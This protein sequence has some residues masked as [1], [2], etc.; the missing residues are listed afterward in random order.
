MV[1]HVEVIGPFRLLTPDGSAVQLK[2]RKAQALLAMLASAGHSGMTRERIVDILW[3]NRGEQQARS[4]LRQALTSVRRS[5]QESDRDQLLDTTDDLIRLNPRNTFTDFEKLHALKTGEDIRSLSEAVAMLDAQ[6]LDGFVSR[7]HA[8]E[9]WLSGE[10]QSLSGL[11]VDLMRRLAQLHIAAGDRE[12]AIAVTQRQLARDEL[13]ETTHRLL[14]G[15]YAEKGD[16][17]QALQ[18]FRVCA[19]ILKQQLGI[20]PDAATL[21]LVDEIKS[22]SSAPQSEP[23]IAN[24]ATTLSLAVL[25]L[26]AITGSQQEKRFADAI[27]RDLMTEL[28]RF[29]ALEVAGAIASLT[30]KGRDVSPSELKTELGVRFAVE[31][32]VEMEGS[33]TRITVQ[34][35]DLETL[36]QIWARRYTVE[37]TSGLQSRD[38]LVATIAG[39]LYPPL[40]AHLRRETLYHPPSDANSTELYAQLF[41]LSNFP[42]QAT[43][44]TAREQCF[45]LIAADP[46]HVQVYESLAWTY[47]HDAINAW[48]SN[49]AERLRRAREAAA[50]GISLNSAEPYVRV[51]MAHVATL[52][53]NSR[54]AQEELHLALACSPNDGIVAALVSGGLAWLGLTES[55]FEQ[56]RVAR[57]LNP[58]YNI[59]AYSETFAHAMDGNMQEAVHACE[60]FLITNP[61][62]HM[63]QAILAACL[64]QTGEEERARKIV[65]DLSEHNSRLSRDWIGNVFANLHGAFVGSLLAGLEKAGMRN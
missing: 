61:D 30:Y 44:E 59:I 58:D 16:R 8:F 40:M 22:K 39:S 53:G 20:E 45:K 11:Q 4:S 62:Y 48:H 56:L 28:G 34:L 12:A 32:A 6:F 60:R 43:Q 63:M 46:L 42:S 15:L 18:Q 5:L 50:K 23:V 3:G 19:E 57:K 65:S 31:G 2:S 51:A 1:Y 36:R 27:T 35:S 47:L 52:E 14:I 54:H 38:E 25:S 55:A 33:Q 26:D 64:A 7:D 17:A 10:R 21:R 29:P 49:P 24:K 41:H 37:L 9:R 13:D